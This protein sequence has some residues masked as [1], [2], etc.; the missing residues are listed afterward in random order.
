M[1]WV[2]DYHLMLMPGMLRKLKPDAPVGFFLHIPFPSYELLK[3]LPEKWRTT[4]FSSLLECDVV[5]FHI[6]EYVSH[7]VRSISYFMGVETSNHLAYY[8]NRVVLVKD[9]PI[10]IDYKKF[11][12]AALTRQVV[13]GRK[14]LRNRYKNL[15]AFFQWTV[16][17][18]PRA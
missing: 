13:N 11:N 6:K 3:L 16:S 14:Q 2:H 5:G 7:F 4:I 1:V 18:T 10:S 17:I 9:Y 8:N 12:E 15:K